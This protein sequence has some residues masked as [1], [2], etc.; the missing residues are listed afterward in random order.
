MIYA[1]HIM[2]WAVPSNQSHS[3][4]LSIPEHTMVLHVPMSP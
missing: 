3:L 4:A 2:I 1:K